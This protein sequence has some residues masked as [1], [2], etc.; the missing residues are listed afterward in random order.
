MMAVTLRFS[1]D[2]QTVEPGAPVPLFL[3][4]VSSTLVGGS[5]EEYIVSADGQRFLMNAF[6]ER[7]DLPITLI[8]NRMVLK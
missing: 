5:G 4:R 6:T 3:T 8:L 7:A 1:S 2:N